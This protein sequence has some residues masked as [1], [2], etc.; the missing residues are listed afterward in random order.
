LNPHCIL[1]IAILRLP[2]HYWECF[3]ASK[4]NK[5][6]ETFSST[7]S[8]FLLVLLLVE[9]TKKSLHN[10]DYFYVNKSNLE[11]QLCEKISILYDKY[12]SSK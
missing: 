2:E 3:A 1:V 4:T 6:L 12:Y 7:H 5:L 9:K 10:K 11:F 8:R